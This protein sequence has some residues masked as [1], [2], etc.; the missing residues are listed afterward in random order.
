MKMNSLDDILS[1]IDRRTEFI[2]F[3]EELINPES[4]IPRVFFLHRQDLFPGFE[5]MDIMVPLIFWIN[6]EFRKIE[7]TGVDT[8]SI[9]KRLS[10]LETMK[11]WD[12]T[13]RFFSS[14]FEEFGK[15]FRNLFEKKP[16]LREQFLRAIFEKEKPEP[17]QYEMPVD[18]DPKQV[19]SGIKKLI[20][21]VRENPLK[22]LATL[23]HIWPDL[24]FYLHVQAPDILEG[25]L[26]K[27]EIDFEIYKELVSQ[28]FA[29]GLVENLDAR[30]WCNICSDPFVLR[31]ESNLGPKSLKLRCIK[32]GKKM[33]ICSIYRLD[34]FLWKLISLRDGLLGV[35]VAWLLKRRKIEYESPFFVKETELDFICN[36]P[37]GKVLLECKMHR[38]PVTDRSVRQKLVD[39]L[40]QL[41]KHVSGFERESKEKIHESYL[42]YNFDLRNY[43]DLVEEEAKNHRDNHVIDFTQLDEIVA[44]LA[45]KE[46]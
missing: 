41:S 28:L 33:A 13:S 3:F 44:S 20:S 16:E 2:Y 42:I 11:S 46:D 24:Y 29:L 30:F 10:E 34:N 6:K 43:Q 15:L 31:S 18:F 9:A 21:K 39:D 23:T 14:L 25:L 19:E 36:T 27:A 7:L 38:V 8:L 5:Q 17:K 35:T 22:Y 1:E 26:A 40:K 12:V 32:C 4:I 37:K 45:P